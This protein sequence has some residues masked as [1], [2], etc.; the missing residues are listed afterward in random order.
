MCGCQPDEPTQKLS[1]P[2][3]ICLPAGEIYT[4]QQAPQMRA[5]GDPG[6]TE[7][8]ALPQYLYIFIVKYEGVGDEGKATLT[9]WKVWEIL[10]KSFEDEEG[11]NE[12]A[13]K[14]AWNARW[15]KRRY[16]GLY[17]TEEDIVYQYT[18]II[19]QLLEEGGFDGRVYVVASAVPLTFT[20]T[21]NGSSTLADLLGMTFRFDGGDAYDTNVRNNLQNIYSTPYNYNGNGVDYYGSF[22]ATQ[23]V[24]HFDLLLYH[25]A[26]KVDLMWNVTDSIDTDDDDEPDTD[27]RSLVKLSYIAVDSL[28]DGPCYLFKP[29][30]NT[31][32]NNKVYPSGYTK[33]LV[34][35]LSPGTQWNGRK[36]FYAIPYKNNDSPTKHYPLK[37]RLQKNGDSSSGASYYSKIVDTEVPE[38]WTS[39]IRGQITVNTATYNVPKP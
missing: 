22:Y 35:S 2:L 36:Y 5:F 28:Y 7:Q 15:E 14:A 30:E 25:V 3:S 11:A 21:I 19:H 38:V 8:F 4:S 12:T 29:T 16:T 31:I 24:P 17:D 1:M 33:V 23:K 6:T 9:N 10:T 20:P 39:W 27:L 13:K 26:A 37:L 34:E 32:G 18:A